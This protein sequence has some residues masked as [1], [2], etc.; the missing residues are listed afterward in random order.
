MIDIKFYKKGKQIC[1]T[2][3]GHAGTAPKGEDLVCAAATMLVYTL[4][5]AVQFLQEQGCFRKRPKME[6][7]DGYAFISAVPGKS[8]E[9]E[10]LMAFWVA[11]AGAYVL[12]RNYPQAV[13]LI[14]ME[15]CMDG[16]V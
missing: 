9:A 4:A 8:V 12:E 3:Q 16:N 6:I 14:P 15:F 1:M 2:V 5:Q 10:V 11:Q 13:K 7:T